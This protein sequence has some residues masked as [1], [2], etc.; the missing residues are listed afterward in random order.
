MKR[1]LQPAPAPFCLLAALLLIVT[2]AC[3]GGSSSPT[4][5]IPPGPTG[6]GDPG[7]DGDG[8]TGTGDEGGDEGGDDG[9]Q[10]GTGSLVIEMTDAPIEDIAEL[11]VYVSGLKLKPAGGPVVWLREPELVPGLY[12]LLNLRNGISVILADAMIEAT[13]YQ[14]IEIELDQSRSYLVEIANPLVEVP[15]QIP[16]NK[17][18]LNGGPFDVLP[19]GTTTVLFDFDAER[20]LHRKGNGQYQLKPFLQ[21][22]EVEEEPSRDG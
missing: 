1:S 11:W 13:T 12:D 18:K 10:S 20:S 2:V 3:S 8:G 14:F 21:I 9:T 4:E 22:L 15:M 7:T 5:T 19:D 17:A 16:S 6:S